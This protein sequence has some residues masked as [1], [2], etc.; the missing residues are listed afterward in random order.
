MVVT[1]TSGLST[2]KAAATSVAG[3]KYIGIGKIKG[4]PMDLYIELIFSDAE[5]T[6]NISGTDLNIPYKTVTTG[7]KT[8]YVL[9]KDG[10]LTLGS[11]TPS[12]DGGS[13]EGAIEISG[14]KMDLWLLKIPSDLVQVQMSDEELAKVFESK[15]G[16]T[17]LFKIT[18]KEGT[19]CLVGDFS[20]D[21]ATK[22]YFFKSDV[23]KVNQV[24]KMFEGKYNISDGHITLIAGT[25]NNTVTLPL[26]CYDNGLYIT[27]AGDTLT[28]VGH[29]S[30]VFIR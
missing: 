23:A 14:T 11:V 19:S 29:I 16:Y 21:P 26:K 27:C 9:A 13:L 15:D 2:A 28:G 4:S 30:F 6:L 8:K 1:L 17:L 5:A 10:V 3:S 25:G 18:Q 20:V 22:R 7:E 24:F 12:A